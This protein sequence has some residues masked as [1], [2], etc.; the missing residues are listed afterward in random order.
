MATRKKFL[1]KVILLGEPGVGK[2]ALMTQFCTK[3]FSAQYRATL[4]AEFLSRDIE[5]DDR[6]VSLQIWDTAGHER[7]Q[8]LGSV[9]F[10]G[11]DACILVF[12]VT[13]KTSF[14]KLTNWHHQFSVQAISSE[15]DTFPFIVIGNKCDKEVDERTVTPHEAKRWCT[16]NGFEYFET[17]AK[18]NTNVEEAFRNAAKKALQRSMNSAGQQSFSNAIP[19]MEVR[20]TESDAD[21]GCSC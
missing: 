3:R 13:N 17:S 21:T 12:D 8:S 20:N 16:H 9:F 15:P 4:G 10:R 7:F 19:T 14:D 5:I 11:A 6:R 2:T 18:E 1:L